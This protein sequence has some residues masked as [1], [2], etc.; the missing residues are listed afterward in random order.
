MTHRLLSHFP[1]CPLADQRPSLFQS[2]SF[3]LD[4]S[5]F[6][7]KQKEAHQKISSVLCP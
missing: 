5:S 6:P 3:A 2:L 1:V 7:R 4:P